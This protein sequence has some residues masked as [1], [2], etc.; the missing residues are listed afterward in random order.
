M[1]H[2]SWIVRLVK[3]ALKDAGVTVKDLANAETRLL[4]CAFGEL[5]CASERLVENCVI[6]FG[7]ATRLFGCVVVEAEVQGVVV[8]VIL[9]VDPVSLVLLLVRFVVGLCS[10]VVFLIG[11]GG[12]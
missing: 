7:N 4:G 5:H 3:Q 6:I 8:V 2:R 12:L 11:N 1:H 10:V 9:A